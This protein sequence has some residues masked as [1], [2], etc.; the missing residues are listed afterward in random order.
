M[1]TATVREL[2]NDFPRL[3]A[4][5]QEGESIS[6]SKRGRIIATLVPA[7]PDQAVTKRV[8]KPDIMSR[9]RETWGS[10]V[11][12]LGEVAAMRE[13]EIKGDMG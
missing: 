4:W 2:R 6:I 13:D 10:R 1:K 3:E 9:L 11:F 7:R 8:V 5:V 12:S